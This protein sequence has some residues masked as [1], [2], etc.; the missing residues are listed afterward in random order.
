V[1]TLS[2]FGPRTARAC[3]DCFGVVQSVSMTNDGLR[4][5]TRPV[6]ATYHGSPLRQEGHIYRMRRAYVPPSV[7]R[8]FFIECVART[9]RPPPGPGHLYRQ[10]STLPAPEA[11]TVVVEARSFCCSY[12][13]DQVIEPAIKYDTL[14]WQ[15]R[16]YVAGKEN[17]KST[18]QTRPSLFVND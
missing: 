11:G 8:A 2:T 15:S 7:R 16:A 1:E 6:G 5:G 18:P 4:L 14:A 3:E 10:L 17:G 9:F 12:L 13:R